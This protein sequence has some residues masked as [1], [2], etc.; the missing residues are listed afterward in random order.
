MDVLESAVMRLRLQRYSYR[1]AEHVLNS[2][3]ALKQEIEDVLLDPGID[4]AYLSRPHFNEVLQKAFVTRD[5]RTNQRCSMKRKIP[6]RNWI[7]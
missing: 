5:G 6:R 1:F 7:S 3:L 2:R 4:I